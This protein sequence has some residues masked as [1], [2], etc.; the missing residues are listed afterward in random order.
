MKR[1]DFKILFMDDEI[2]ITGQAKLGYQNLIDSGYQVDKSD[3]ISEVID[4]FDD[5]FYHLYILDID[6]QKVDDVIKGTGMTV[7]ETLKRLSSISEILIFSAL[8][9]VEDWF[10]AA[11]YG[12]RGYVHKQEGI[13][14]LLEKIDEF[15][16]NYQLDDTFSLRIDKPKEDKALLYYKG[17]DKVLEK[18]RI[19]DLLKTKGIKE[20]DKVSKLSKALEKVKK[21]DY[22]II[23][24]FADT[25]P[26]RGRVYEPLME[27]AKLSP[28]PH[29]II[30]VYGDERSRNDII[31]LVN[32]RPFR[33]LN[34][35]W[36]NL[37][38][39]LEEGVEDALTWYGRREILDL[40]EK[41][42]AISKGL[43]SRDFKGLIEESGILLEE[44]GDGNE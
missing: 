16:Q 6:M 33:L 36:A 24:F 35:G 11:N 18:D 27:V 43:D 30:G 38:T 40:P 37:M 21:E 39:R 29:I 15:R 5:N 13:E 12:F 10:E 20:V 26:N 28:S 41:E 44:E 22:K 42:G 2:D 3:K 4:G 34:L 1:E 17:G 32:L 25:F 31:P 8:G 7:G 14:R 9:N 23:L 19:V